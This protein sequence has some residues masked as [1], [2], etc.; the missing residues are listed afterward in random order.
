MWQHIL[1]CFEAGKMTSFPLD[2]NYA[3]SIDKGGYQ[4]Q[5]YINTQATLQMQAAV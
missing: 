1:E 2:T 3:T 5:K 4:D